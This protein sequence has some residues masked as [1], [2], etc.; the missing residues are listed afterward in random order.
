MESSPPVNPPARQREK[1][2]L[3]ADSHILPESPQA[4]DFLEMLRA[5][6][7]TDF[8]VAFLGDVFDLWIALPGYELPIQRQ[9]AEWCRRQRDHRRILFTEGNHELFVASDRRDCFSA[10][11]S[12]CLKE[13]DLVLAHGDQ[14]QEGVFGF[15]RNFMALAKSWVGRLVLSSIPGGPHFSAWVKGLL[16][17]RHHAANNSRKLPEN[18][19]RDWAAAQLSASPCAQV[20]VGHYHRQLRLELPDKG[21]CTVLPAW[22]YG[23]QVALLESGAKELR[24]GN[25]REIVPN[26]PTALSPCETGEGAPSPD[27]AKPRPGRWEILVPFCVSLLYILLSV[28]HWK[29][30]ERAAWEDILVPVMAVLTLR[31]LWRNRTGRIPLEITLLSVYLALAGAA[32]AWHISQ[33]GA[34]LPHC[35]EWA[36]F[37]YGAVVFS[38]FA[39][40]GLPPLLMACLGVL[41]LL[42]WGGG[43]LAL[44]SGHAPSLGF[45]SAEMRQTHLA[46]LAARYAFTMVNPNLAAPFCAL[47]FTMLALGLPSLWQEITHRTRAAL[48]V[49]GTVALAWLGLVHTLSKHA[50]L[51][52]AVCAASVADGL[53]LRLPRLARA[54]WVPIVLAGLVCE[55]TVLFVTFPVTGKRPFVNTVPGMYTIHQYAYARMLCAERA[56]FGVGAER[57]RSLYSKFVDPEQTRRTLAQYNQNDKLEVF[58]NAMDPHCEYLNQLLLF[59]PLPLLAMLAFWLCLARRNGRV[60]AALA[61]AVLF[62]MLWDDL[63]SRRW[64]WVAA[65]LCVAESTRRHFRN[66][67]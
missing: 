35:Y 30:G 11:S 27:T 2:L 22:K 51:S 41:L 49:A 64:L 53:A 44:V 48:I 40:H 25:W 17:S 34:W 1:W 59:G 62:C 61:L 52:L 10:S 21:A 50:L 8:N 43:W 56:F 29:I 5:V 3:L 12:A 67:A 65:G 7:D 9:F 16:G 14:A 24:V 66:L 39:L 58:L 46:F 26:A 32:T 19:I 18:R 6:E 23:G 60:A 36:V 42:L 47:P 28:F 45:F 37:A 15:N 54:A 4:T 55:C 31:K 63:L 33:G 13:G 20:I 57:A 38:F